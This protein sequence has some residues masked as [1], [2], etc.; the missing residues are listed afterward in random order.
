MRRLDCLQILAACLDEQAL[1]VTSLSSN[2]NMWRSLWQRGPAFLGM[3]MGLC[4]PFAAG[5]SVA[6]PE[7]KVIALDSDG[8]LMVDPSSLIL[9]AAVNPPNLVAIVFDNQAYAVMGPTA[10]REV[11]DLE[12]MAQGAGI[13]RTATVRTLDEFREVVTEAVA[14]NKLCFVVAR[15]ETEQERFQSAFG[16]MSERGMKEAFVQA[17]ARLPDYQG[18]AYAAPPAREPEP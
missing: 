9:L 5:L 10:T 3:N 16:R 4:L 15:V 6:F 12:K 7:R 1:S 8:G 14:G 17:L 13:R 2:A 11:T 18:G